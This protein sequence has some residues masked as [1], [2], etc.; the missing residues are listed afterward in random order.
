MAQIILGSQTFSILIYLELNLE[1][2]VLKDRRIPQW[3]SSP[4]PRLALFGV[5]QE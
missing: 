2:P 5:S 4:G 3:C 1:H